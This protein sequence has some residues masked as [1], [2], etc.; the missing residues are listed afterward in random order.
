MKS[1]LVFLSHS[2]QDSWI[3]G[4]IVEAL[5]QGGKPFR[6]EVFLDERSIEGGDDIAE[7][8]RKAIEQCDEFVVLMSRYSVDRN[9]VVAEIGAAWGQRKR[10]TAIADKVTPQEMPKVIGPYKSVDLN[11]FDRFSKQVIKR[12]EKKAE[13]A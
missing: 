8:I 7:E 2:T 6:V 1:Y 4:K 9:W 10:I 5:E 12:A 13:K 3:A 11:D